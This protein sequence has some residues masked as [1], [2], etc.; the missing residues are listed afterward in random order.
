MFSLQGFMRPKALR[1]CVQEVEPQFE[2]AA[3]TQRRS[4]RIYL[5]DTIQGLEPDHPALRRFRM[6]NHTVCADQIPS[7]SITQIYEWKPLIEFLVAAMNKP[8]LYKM[9]DPLA[10]I[11]VMCYCGAK[12]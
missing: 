4:H 2:S 11:N 10:R 7:S 6:I 1:R 9:A 12:P 8:R 3:F 5:D